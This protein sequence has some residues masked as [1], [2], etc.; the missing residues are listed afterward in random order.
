M[1][2]GTCH[3]VQEGSKVYKDGG[4][5]NLCLPESRAILEKMVCIYM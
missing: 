1:P 2:A 5:V 4:R 3:H